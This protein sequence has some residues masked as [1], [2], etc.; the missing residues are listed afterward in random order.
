MC[1]MWLKYEMDQKKLPGLKKMDSPKSIAFNWAA[2]FLFAN[3]KFS[4][5]RSR[6]ITPC[7]WHICIEIC[8]PKKIVSFHMIK[9]SQEYFV[10]QKQQAQQNNCEEQTYA[11]S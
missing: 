9:I 5:L 2:S 4:G 7:L 6:W 11:S 1:T 8:I 3:K 10:L